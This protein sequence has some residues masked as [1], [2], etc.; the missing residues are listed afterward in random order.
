MT[1]ARFLIGRCGYLACQF[2]IR[3]TS[4]DR[5]PAPVDALLPLSRLGS[6]ILAADDAGIAYDRLRL[7]FLPLSRLIRQ[8][9]L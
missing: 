6:Q 8:E 5:F 1:Y 9:G 7:H 3:L 2:D 4:L